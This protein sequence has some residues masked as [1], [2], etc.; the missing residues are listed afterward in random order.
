MHRSGVTFCHA[1]WSDQWTASERQSTGYWDIIN[2]LTPLRNECNYANRSEH[3]PSFFEKKFKY[4]RARFWKIGTQW[5]NQILID[6]KKREWI[7]FCTSFFLSKFYFDPLVYSFHFGPSFSFFLDQI[8]PL[9][10]HWSPAAA[11][12]TC[13]LYRIGSGRSVQANHWA[14][15]SCLQ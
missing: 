8:W 7:V 3:V 12:R 10:L 14:S 11:S 4:I 1:K 6:N 5:H 9:Y 15:C 2:Y 13:G